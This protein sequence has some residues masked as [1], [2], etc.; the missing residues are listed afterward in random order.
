MTANLEAIKKLIKQ[1][2]FKELFLEVL[3]WDHHNSHVSVQI[4]DD[5]FDLT[6]IAEKRGFVVFLYEAP[7]GTDLPSRPVRVRLNR[8]LRKTA[9]EHMAIFLGSEQDGQVWQWAYSAG[10]GQSSRFR[11]RRVFPDQS[12]EGLAQA[13]QQLAVTLAEEEQLT[14][15]HVTGR[16][17]AAF[18][19]DRV[20][21]RFYD[22]FKEEQQAFLDFI[23]GLESLSQREWYASLMLN[24]LMFIYFMQRKGYLDGDVNYLRSRLGKLQGEGRSDQ[25][26][27]FYRHFLL[28]LFHE[29]LGGDERT[30][31]LDELLGEVPYLNGGLFDVHTLEQQNPDIQVPDEAFERLFDFFD[32]Y[33]WHLDERPLRADNEINPDVLGYIFEKYVNQKQMGA[34]YTKEDV[35]QFITHGSLL[36]EIVE[37]ARAQYPDTFDSGGQFWHL[38]EEDVD[39]YLY[40][41]EAHGIELDLPDDIAEGVDNVGRRSR[42]NA[43]AAAT[44]GLPRE[45]WRECIDR[46]TRVQALRQRIAEQELECVEDLVATNLD[47]RQ[48]LLD[49]IAATQDP[50]VLRSLFHIIR[51]V[52]VL[53]PTCGSGAFLFAA[54]NL[55]EPLYEACL[56]RMEAMIEE[57]LPDMPNKVAKEFQETIDA[58]NA[59]PSSRYFVLKT[60]ILTNLY[61][62]DIMEEAVEICKLRLFLKLTAQLQD[63]REIEPLP[64]IDFNIRAGNTLV[65]FASFESLEKALGSRLDLDQTVQRIR[66]GA[67]EAAAAFR[68]FREVQESPSIDTEELRSA[69]QDLIEKLTLLRDELDQRL[70]LEYGVDPTS[71]AFSEWKTSHQPFHWVVEFYEALVAG[72]FDVVIGNPPY[73]ELSKVRDYAVRGF[74]TLSCGNLYTLCVERSGELLGTDG[75]FGMIVPL[76][77]FFTGRMGPYQDHVRSRYNSLLISYFSGDA[78]PSVMFEGVK[79]RLTIVMGNT[80]KAQSQTR[81]TDYRRWYAEEREHLFQTLRFE[82]GDF[83][84]GF[85][86]FAKLGSPEAASILKKLLGKRPRIGKHLVRTGGAVVN[87]HRSPVFWIRSMDFEP[88]FKS[89]TRQRSL[90]HL[91]DLHVVPPRLSKAVGAVI[92]STLFYFWFTVQGNCRNLTGGDIEGFPLG[93]LKNSTAKQLAKQFDRLMDDLKEHS[94]T[95]VYNYRA[96][97]RVEYQEFYPHHSKPIIDEIDQ[98]LA[99]HYGFNP[100]ETDYLLNFDIKYRMRGAEVEES[101]SATG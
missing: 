60:I 19:V 23:Q 1:A 75:H 50:N 28:R 98:T 40:P 31:E 85:L 73:V 55:L 5:Q 91:R 34:Y 72:G 15:S 37:R 10:Q 69:K 16:V 64:D 70:A 35:T 80:S 26:F 56:E 33:Q 63:V 84:A 65:G 62:V 57:H 76:S 93:S 71:L 29:G 20:T 79:Y 11:E 24:R 94:A 7:S 9:H 92:N 21:R 12:G 81:T 67:D 66:E 22:R 95:R 30:S 101:T 89:A 43:E 14:I 13:V 96:S 27:S 45:T 61:G 88:Y 18:D 8:E 90:D 74:A 58:V 49:L 48:L 100:N 41:A 87:Y 17:R 82:M 86:R 59:H 99:T 42:W 32:S 78:H 83:D 36:G 2:A 47:G 68:V 44:H 97:G 6:S 25:F 53:D 52:R 46:R 51:G 3:G 38:L 77:G 54:L 39:R 4:G